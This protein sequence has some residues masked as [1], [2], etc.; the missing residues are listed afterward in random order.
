[1]NFF[2]SF[3]VKSPPLNGEIRKGTAPEIDGIVWVGN[4]AKNDGGM[5][6][7]SIAAPRYN[8]FKSET[9]V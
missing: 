5:I 3:H 7:G 1:M 9:Q 6:R 8:P 2:D 4:Q